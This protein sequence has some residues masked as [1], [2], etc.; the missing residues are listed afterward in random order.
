MGS[1]VVSWANM[2]LGSQ[3]QALSLTFNNNINKLN[4]D[5]VVE[6]VWYDYTLNNVNVTI[7][8]VGI[9]A[10]NVTEIKF[11]DPSNWNDLETKKITDGQ[12]L[13][14]ESFSTNVTYPGLTPGDAFNVVVTSERGNIIQKQ[15]LPT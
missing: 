11:T 4:E 10:L 8:N 2:K 5:F 13:V 15:V 12:I 1:L 3:E 6:N 14:Q 9:L 7:T